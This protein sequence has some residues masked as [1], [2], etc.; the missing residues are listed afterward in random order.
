MPTFPTPN[1]A[2][3]RQAFVSSGYGPRG[4]GYHRGVDLIFHLRPYD[5][6]KI[7]EVTVSQGKYWH[8]KGLPALSAMDGEVRTVEVTSTG[9]HIYINHSDG[10]ASQYIHL[11]PGSFRVKPGQRVREGQPIAEISGNIEGKPAGQT[12]L[13]HLHFQL[14]KDGNLLDPEP[15]IANWEHVQSPWNLN[16]VY[17]AAAAA[18]IYLIS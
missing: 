1:L 12:G 11:K 14:R 6:P 10:W 4:T 8:P 7:N 9:G 18:V 15:I 3:Q 2:D 5:F 13:I 17:I 16:F